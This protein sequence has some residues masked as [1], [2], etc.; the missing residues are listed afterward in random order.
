MMA[1][2]LLERLSS[3]PLTWGGGSLADV[4]EM[5]AKYIAALRAADNHDIGPLLEFARS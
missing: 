3:P 1:D 5:R 4:G 2:L